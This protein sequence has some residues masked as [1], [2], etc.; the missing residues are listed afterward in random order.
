MS[1][2]TSKK[3]PPQNVVSMPLVHAHAAGIDIS[4]KEHVVAVPENICKD[5]VRKFGAMTCDLKLI[6]VWLKECQIETV[7]M[8]STGVYWKPLFSLLVQEG[9]E[10]YLVNSKTIKNVSG[11]KTDED[12]A[13]WIQK[14]HSCALLKSSYLPDDQQDMLRTLVRYRRSLVQDSSRFV[15]RMQKA[16]ELMNI[17]FHTVINDIVGKT[18]TAVVE[19]II[20]GERTAENFLPLIGKTIKADHETIRKS[21]EGNWRE[22]HL[23]TLK[24]SY[25]LYKTYQQRIVEFDKQIEKQLQQYEAKCNEGIIEDKKNNSNKHEMDKSNVAALVPM[26]PKKVKKKKDK[27]HPSFDTRGFLE[28]ILGV[29]VMAI[30]G[31]SETSGLEILAET[32]TDLSRWEN[33]AH[34]RSWLNLCPNNKISGGKV[35]SSRMMKKKPN[36]ASQAFRYAANGVQRS[37]NWLG[38]YFRRMKAKGGNKYAV[39]A[40]AAKIATIYYKMVRYKEEFTPLDLE[41]YKEKHKLAKISYLERALK[42]LK[43]EAA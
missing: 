41:E 28:R 22:D 9:F 27:N 20:S 16:M 1:K 29:D 5:R 38:D 42:R 14:L 13:M 23:F 11:R 37:D 21:L 30:F 17:K 35:I 19:A 34:F 15:N 32:G 3:A 31:L 6:A 24:E 25:E 33:E 10:V 36:A 39:L 43:G 12:D 18:G 7:A 4:D 8:E 2:K 26:K 40:T